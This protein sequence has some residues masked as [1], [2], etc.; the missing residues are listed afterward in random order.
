[1]THVQF[2]LKKLEAKPEIGVENMTR[3]ERKQRAKSQGELFFCKKE[4]LKI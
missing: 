4:F 2:V 1:M 3:E